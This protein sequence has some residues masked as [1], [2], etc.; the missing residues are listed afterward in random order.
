MKNLLLLVIITGSFVVFSCKAKESDRFRFLTDPI[1]V[2]DSLLVNGVDATGPGG[3]LTNFLGDTKFNSDGT[4]YFGDYEGT[5]R[6]NTDET[7][8]VIE[9]DSLPIPVIAD[10]KELTSTSLKLTAPLPNLTDPLHPFKIRMTFKP[11]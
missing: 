6:F 4:G 7:K 8:L 5:W 2:T 11:K 3:L 10:I 9:T 1:W